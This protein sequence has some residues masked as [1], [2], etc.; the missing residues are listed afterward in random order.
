MN[1][2]YEKYVKDEVFALVFYDLEL[3]VERPITGFIRLI[4]ELEIKRRTKGY[5]HNEN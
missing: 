1:T 3:E 5:Y 2:Y 4:V